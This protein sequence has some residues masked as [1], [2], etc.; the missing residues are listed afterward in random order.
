M[1]WEVPDDV[2]ELATTIDRFQE[3]S[4]RMVDISVNP[5][6]EYTYMSVCDSIV[7]YL[8]DEENIV[9]LQ[10]DHVVTRETRHADRRIVLTEQIFISKQTC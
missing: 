3:T 8:S 2:L 9:Y 10:K 4:R 7:T 1:R 6:H 5:N